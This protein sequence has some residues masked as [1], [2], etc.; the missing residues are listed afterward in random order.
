MADKDNPNNNYA[1]YND[2]N[3][4]AI[5]RKVESSGTPT[6]SDAGDY[7]TYAGDTLSNGIRITGHTHYH[8]SGGAMIQSSDLNDASNTFYD[9]VDLPLG[10]SE[11]LLCYVKSRVM[12]DNGQLEQAQY[13]RVK[14]DMMVKKH[15]TRKS[16]V[17]RLSLPRI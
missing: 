10:L 16:G 4:L 12:E 13:F 14:Y 5:V 2:D 7:D 15:P 9:L 1:W 11:A 3:R 6:G 8:K 17:R